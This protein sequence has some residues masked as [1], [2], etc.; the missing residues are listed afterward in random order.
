M[1]TNPVAKS[2]RLGITAMLAANAE[3][4]LRSGLPAQLHC[5]FE[6][7]A[8]TDRIQSAEWVRL[9][10]ILLHVGFN[11]L[12]GIVSRQTEGHLR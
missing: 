7:L 8:D 2:N 4:E 5:H 1:Q 3:L 6:Q 12:A 9:Q 11:H 10:N